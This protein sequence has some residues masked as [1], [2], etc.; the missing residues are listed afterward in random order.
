M[1][2]LADMAQ[3]LIDESLGGAPTAMSWPV[4]AGD[5]PPSPDECIALYQFSGLA[6]DT[7]VGKRNPGLQIVV[8]GKSADER[9]GG[10]AS[11]EAKAA[12]ILVGV[13]GIGAKTINGTTYLEI[14]AESD[15]VFRGR[16]G[17]GRPEMVVNFIVWVSSP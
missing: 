9:M 8:R 3:L 2:F 1:G 15:V 17:N 14:L 4:Y 16:D 7:K 13:D 11:A 10:Y 12:A 6:P 5:L